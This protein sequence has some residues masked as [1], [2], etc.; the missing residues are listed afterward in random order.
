M[1]MNQPSHNASQG[2]L[3]SMDS[4]IRKTNSQTPGLG[5]DQKGC[6]AVARDAI[7][8]ALVYP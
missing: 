3:A 4:G 1:L 2:N 8:N 7:D 5:K 6:Y